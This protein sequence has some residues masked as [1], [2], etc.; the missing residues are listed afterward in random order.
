MGV[1]ATTSVETRTHN[2]GDVV[3]QRRGKLPRGFK[4]TVLRSGGQ[5]LERQS[6]TSRTSLFDTRGNG[7]SRSIPYAIA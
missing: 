5:L 1:S 7:D 6:S 4:M 2:N 3:W